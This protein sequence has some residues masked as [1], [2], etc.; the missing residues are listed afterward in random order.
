MKDGTPFKLRR[1]VLTLPESI[2]GRAVPFPSLTTKGA[3]KSQVVASAI[4]SASLSTRAK[5]T[6]SAELTQVIDL[7]EGGSLPGRSRLSKSEVRSSRRS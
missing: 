4:L 3:R 2:T 6:S 5:L 7:F 1:A